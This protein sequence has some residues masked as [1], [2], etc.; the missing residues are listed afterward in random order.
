MNSLCF[1]FCFTL[2]RSPQLQRS[3]DGFGVVADYF[4]RG[5][6]NKV[7]SLTG[8]KNTLAGYILL[9]NVTFD[10]GLSEVGTQ[11]NRPLYKGHCL[12]S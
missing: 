10:S 3:S 12:R 1:N 11:C 8:Y 9:Y 7:T 2:S 5:V 4:G 6:F